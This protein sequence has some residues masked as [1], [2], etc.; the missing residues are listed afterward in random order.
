[1]REN[2]VIMPLV[3]SLENSN[4]VRVM[5]GGLRIRL[6]YPG[7]FDAPITIYL[8][9]TARSGIR[10]VGESL[11]FDDITLD[12]LYFST[13]DAGLSPANRGIIAEFLRAL[14]QSI[15]NDSLNDAL[16]ALP[17]PSFQLPNNLSA[18]GLP[19][20]STLGV[21]SPTLSSSTNHIILD[22]SFGVQ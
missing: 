21:V 16:P 10:L 9:A 7:L 20:G 19:G 14:V 2:G 8:G 3:M 4:S 12:E 6:T 17:I 11:Q 15:I 1:M 5:L 22:G 18:Y 13:E